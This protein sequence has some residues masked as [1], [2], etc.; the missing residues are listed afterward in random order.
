MNVCTRFV[1]CV[2]NAI[3]FFIS[4]QHIGF[5]FFFFIYNHHHHHHHLFVCVCVY[6]I[7]STYL[8]NEI[9]IHCSLM[10]N[11]FLFPYLLLSYMREREREEIYLIFDKESDFS[12]VFILS[13][14]LRANINAFW[15]YM[16]ECA[17]SRFGIFFCSS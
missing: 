4:F 3:I 17:I 12:N 13:I 6:V 9:V 1:I 16:C 2:V 8:S 5:F 14:I 15:V 10:M 11:N 7:F